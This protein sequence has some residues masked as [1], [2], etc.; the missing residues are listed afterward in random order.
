VNKR[1]QALYMSREEESQFDGLIK[2]NDS[3]Y[4]QSI[5]QF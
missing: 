4:I 2:K 5:I 3:E 1:A